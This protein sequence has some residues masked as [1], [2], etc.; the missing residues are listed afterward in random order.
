M[1]PYTF[2]ILVARARRILVDIGGFRLP[3]NHITFLLGESGIGKS[4]T[5]KAIYG[6]LD[7][8]QLSVVMNGEQYRSYRRDRLTRRFQRDGFFVFQEPSTHLNPLMNLDEQI[9]EGSLAN[10]TSEATVLRELWKDAAAEELMEL[11]RVYPKPHRPS[12]GEKQRILCAMA[13]MKMDMLTPE[14]DADPLFVFDEPTGSLDNR[15]R[16]V[17]L[18][19]LFTRFRRR[20]STVLLI[21][22]DYSMIS[23]VTRNFPDLA[24]RID[25]QELSLGQDG[26][27]LKQFR[28]ET[29]STWLSL[30]RPH[31]KEHETSITATPLL[32]VESGME[33]FGRALR[34]SREP[35][36]KGE[37]VPLI[38]HRATFAYL[39]APSGT[40]KT[41]MVKLLMGLLRGKKLSAR[42]GNME[43]S[44][45]TPKQVWRKQIWGKRMTM[46]F[47][48]ADE[49]L[50][51]R[52]SVR[53]VFSGLPL[54]HRL[55]RTAIEEEVR[56]FFGT[57]LDASFFD[58]T[59]GTLSGG[60][61]QRLN[62]LRSLLLDADLLILDEP[63][64][65]LDF[66]SMQRVLKLLQERMEEGKSL[67]LISHNEEI[68][69]ALVPPENVY[70]LSA[71]PLS[72]SSRS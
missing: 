55:S 4:L 62:L 61:K 27:H 47:Q 8:E 25:F 2:D 5:G 46:V 31:R 42:L 45:R 16:D 32:R 13:F 39:K 70:Y 3:R 59:V 40:G 67:L 36:G 50:N 14:D 20:P 17:V 41:T 66:T 35:E 51:L 15:Y 72:P 60:Q 10:A 6:L 56:S 7:P 53:D 11:L 49:A 19:M 71:L 29:Y 21:T 37:E 48:H 58:R 43:L 38:L 33:A 69:D 64:N 22:H 9:R 28:P 34:F 54:R 57:G 1:I 12:G 24:D 65:G 44:D 26:L 23:F 52:A 30:Q 68:F 18:E 63:L